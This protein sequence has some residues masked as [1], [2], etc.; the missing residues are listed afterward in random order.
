MFG[1]STNIQYLNTSH[2]NVQYLNKSD[3]RKI[4]KFKY[5]SC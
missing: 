2:V 1:V 5:I 3:E 4:K